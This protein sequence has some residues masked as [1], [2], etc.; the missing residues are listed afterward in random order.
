MKKLL[1]IVVLGLL[2]SELVYAGQKIIYL[3]GSSWKM[4]D[5][6]DKDFTFFQDGSCENSYINL[7]RSTYKDCQW[8]Q[9]GPKVK[10]IINKGY[11][12]IDG[13][14]S[15]QNF[16]GRT[17]SKS[18]G[19]G[20]IRGYVTFYEK[21]YKNWISPEEQK[22]IA[23]EKKRLE[24]EKEMQRQAR[25]YEERKRLAELNNKT[26]SSS[27]GRERAKQVMSYKG[28]VAMKGFLGGLVGLAIGFGLYSIMDRKIKRKLNDKFFLG[29]A[30]FIGWIITKFT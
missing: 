15:G 27:S 19:T 23:E 16:K 30:F 18:H 24:Y 17:L 4:N 10:I 26:N 22:R 11:Y 12:I 9:E 8:Q 3:G 14:I 21:V 5:G 1:A 28:G 29:A 2:W 20:D 7:W 6:K 13:Y 25:E